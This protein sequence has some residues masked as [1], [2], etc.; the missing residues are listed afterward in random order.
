VPLQAAVVLE[1]AAGAL[2]QLLPQRRTEQLMSQA[3]AEHTALPV[4]AAGGEQR[5]PQ[6]RQL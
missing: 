6:V 5:L 3:D 2:Q 4:P 1:P